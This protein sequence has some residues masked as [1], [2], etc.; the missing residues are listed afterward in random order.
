M[1]IANLF[2]SHRKHFRE[3]IG[4]LTDQ[5]NVEERDL[6]YAHDRATTRTLLDLHRSGASAPE[7]VTAPRGGPKAGSKAAKERAKRAAQTRAKRRK[8]AEAHTQEA[9][10]AAGGA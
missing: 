5:D 6:L 1:D 3:E 4:Y 8:D 2:E 9:E 7:P 10:S